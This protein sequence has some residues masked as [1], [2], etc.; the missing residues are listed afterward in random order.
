MAVALITGGDSGIGRAVALLSHSR[1]R[2]RRADEPAQEPA[3]LA[4]ATARAPGEGNPF[5]RFRFSPVAWPNVP[6]P[7]HHE[8]A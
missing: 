8:A 6:L 1:A 5:A 7:R 3:M 2:R 4:A